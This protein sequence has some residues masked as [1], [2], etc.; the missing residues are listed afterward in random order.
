MLRQVKSYFTV[1]AEV[2]SPCIGAHVGHNEYSEVGL[3]AFDAGLIAV[4]AGVYICRSVNALTWLKCC[5][6]RFE[7]SE[8]A[9]NVQLQC[10]MHSHALSGSWL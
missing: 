2:Y 5:G 10:F 9:K 7:C 3:N 6:K 8:A 1:S 4:A